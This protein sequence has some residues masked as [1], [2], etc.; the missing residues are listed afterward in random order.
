[1]RIHIIIVCLCFSG[2]SLIAQNSQIGVGFGGTTYAGDLNA[3]STFD[4]IGL[5]QFAFQINY[6]YFINSNMNIRLNAMF[7]NLKGDDLR[8][9]KPWQLERNLDF[10]SSLKEYT[11][12]F[13]Y[14]LWDIFSQNARQRFTP[15][16][17]LGVALFQFDPEASYLDPDGTTKTVKL[18]PLGTEGQGIVGYDSPYSLTEFAIPFG[19]GIRYALTENL[20]VSVELISRV[21]FT[22]YIDDVSTNY[23][24]RDDL[25][26]KGDVGIISLY[27]SNQSDEALGLPQNDINSDKSGLV[28]GDDT[29]NDFYFSGMINFAY[30]L[31]GGLFSRGSGAM[32]CPSF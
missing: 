15:F 26:S 10:Q 3:P 25:L 13:E 32:G 18:Q 1:M 29:S 12:A 23:P 5:T 6:S 30:R 11:L 20:T 14:S 2:F 8:S 7:G 27:M 17:T 28:R 21:T 22:D 19:G 4:K 24:G 31:N 16:A 9:D